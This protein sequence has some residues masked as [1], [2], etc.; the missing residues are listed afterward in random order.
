MQGWESK[1][2][3][4]SVCGLLYWSVTIWKLGQEF[5]PANA[6]QEFHALGAG[7]PFF[8][9]ATSRRGSYTIKGFFWVGDAD[10]VYVTDKTVELYKVGILGAISCACAV[11]LELYKMR[12]LGVELH[13]VGT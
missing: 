10:V 3:E 11:S 8:S 13:K 6:R 5:A 1:N 4:C 2:K 12:T 7:K 9:Q